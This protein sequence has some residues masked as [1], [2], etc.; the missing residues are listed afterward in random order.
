MYFEDDKGKIYDEWVNV[1][2]IKEVR[3]SEKND[4]GDLLMYTHSPDVFYNKYVCI[5]YCH[6][7]GGGQ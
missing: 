1:K 5:P 6:V 2:E 7:F 4:F 3:E